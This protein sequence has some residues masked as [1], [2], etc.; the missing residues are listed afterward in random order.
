MLYRCAG[1]VHHLVNRAA[2]SSTSG[3]LARPWLTWGTGW[4]RT[5]DEMGVVSCCVGSG[6]TDGGARRV[7]EGVRPRCCGQM[8]AKGNKVI[9]EEKAE[10]RRQ[11]DRGGGGEVRSVGRS[12]W[13]NRVGVEQ[14]SPRGPCGLCFLFFRF[15]F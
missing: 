14:R 7:P 2:R 6:G 15:R 4:E 9:K 1:G 13:L 5:G 8:D 10:R 12:G 11:G 3:L